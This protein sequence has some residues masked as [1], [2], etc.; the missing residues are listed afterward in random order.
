M[1]GLRKAGAGAVPR[2]IEALPL[3][4]RVQNQ[5]L[6]DLLAS[7]VSPKSMGQF[8]EGLKHD[9]NRS[10]QGVVKA[11]ST[12]EQFD[13]GP[14]VEL[15]DNPDVS[16]PAVLEILQNAG[17]RINLRNLLRKAYDLE[18]REKSAAFKL[19]G[20]HA[21]EEIIP[22]LIN[23]LD[24]RD[25]TVKVHL[26]DVLSGFDQPEVAAALEK[27]LDDS[28]KMV[29]QTALTALARMKGAKDA[30]K[31]CALLADPDIQVQNRAVDLLIDINDPEILPNLVELLKDES[32]Y[33][34]RSVV[35]VLNGI[36]D[37][38]MIKHLL[39]AIKDD[40][41]WVRSRASDAL[42]KIGGE[43]VRE[44]VLELV[45]DEDENIRRAAIEIL[46]QTGDEAAVDY[47]IEATTDGDWWVRERAA[48]ALGEIGDPRAMESLEKMLA[49][50][51]RSVPVAL[52]ALA[53]LGDE[54][55]VPKLVPLLDRPEKEIRVETLN[56]LARLSDENI[57]DTVRSH[58]E[59]LKADND[60][61][62]SRAASEALVELGNRFSDTMVAAAD[63]A[64]RMAQPERTMLAKDLPSVSAASPVFEVSTLKKGDLIDGRYRFIEKIGKGAFGTVILVEDTVVGEQLILKFLNPSVSSDGETMKRFVHELRFSRKITHRNVIRIYDFLNLGGNYAI[65]MEFFPSHTLGQELKQKNPLPFEKAVGWSR[66][67]ATGMTVAHQVGIIHRD[68]KPANLLINDEGLL[69]IVDF[70]VAAAA[71]SG[72]TQLTRTGYVIGSPKYMAPEQILGKKVDQRAD[73]Y[74]LGVIMYE[75]V[76]GAA[77][78]TKGDHMAVMYQHVQGK[79]RPCQEVNPEIPTPLA[80]VVEKSMDVDKMKRY[81]SMEDLRQDLS[82]ISIN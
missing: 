4:D 27:Q 54:T 39:N 16:T 3:A 24:G 44:A 37:T 7:M 59:P 75:M 63:K 1:D 41:W 51:A 67:I 11:L 47:L 12:A 77:P 70:G 26:I 13:T 72:D 42:A 5:E 64:E 38:R 30:K 55:L 82:Q 56:A 6:V 49:G 14:I 17:G 69:K 21:N 43:R 53:K 22:E 18:P 60:G 52:R 78:Y 65:S 20:R 71:T 73:I 79:A 25:H 31:I 8:I 34:R 15:L 61:T 48:D 57:A 45:R 10:V 35:E 2:I 58:I 66:D 46:N 9:N 76:T 62:I 80:A 28:N 29:R 68:L 32:E 40:D 19:L 23:R 36:A 33:T 81:A 50:D 74:S